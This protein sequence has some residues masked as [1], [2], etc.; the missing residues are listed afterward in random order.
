MLDGASLQVEQVDRLRAQPR[1]LPPCLRAAIRGARSTAAA[2]RARPT[3]R[4]RARIDDRGIR[5][6]GGRRLHGTLFDIGVAQLLYDGGASWST[7]ADALAAAERGDGSEL[8]FWADTYTGRDEDGRYGNLQDSFLAIGC[9]DGPSV[10]DL[11]EPPDDR[12]GG[13]GSGATA[14]TFDR[15]QLAGV[16]DL[17]RAGRR[18]RG[19]HRAERRRSCSCSGRERPRDAAVVGAQPRPPAG[20]RNARDGGGGP[21]HLG[22]RRQ[23]VASTGSSSATSIDLDV[24]RTG[25]GAERD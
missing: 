14:R 2:S 18:A 24:P 19:A 7:L 5:A 21:A 10:G 9:A 4:L 25:R 11:V 3:T 17:A 13:S 6:G 1:S 22:G 12:V 15:Q 16:R 8:L 23:R 20:H